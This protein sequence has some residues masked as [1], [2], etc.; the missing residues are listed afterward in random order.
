MDS[1]EYFSEVA[2]RVKKNPIR[3][4]AYAG[5]KIYDGMYYRTVSRYPRGVNVL[6]K[7]WDLLII[8]DACRY[9]ALAEVCSEYDWID[10]VDKIRSIGTVTTEW[11]SQTFD[12]DH[13]DEVRKLAYI[14]SNPQAKVVFEHRD[15]P[16]GGPLPLPDA[17]WD[18]VQSTDFYIFDRAWENF[19]PDIQSIPPRPVTDRAIRIGRHKNPERMVVHYS[20]PHTPFI[21]PES[22]V[23]DYG[24][25]EEN[26]DLDA[27]DV[28]QS[29]MDNLRY[30]LEDVQLLIQ[31]VDAQDVR[32]T[33]D[34][35]DLLGELDIY[36]HPG[37]CLHPKITMVPWASATASDTGEYAPDKHRESTDASTKEILEDLG[38]IL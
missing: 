7:E 14:C 19:D 34:H 29:Y 13:L 11:M 32:I 30:V 5:Y 22:T 9:E 31:S 15:L 38:Y 8:L 36:G 25:Y 10:S 16:N 2:R 37:G 18:V 20:Q 33:A 1:R 4:A 27:S 24:N 28:R 6:D 23:H 3:G 12:K 26:L 21:D 35:G 17:D